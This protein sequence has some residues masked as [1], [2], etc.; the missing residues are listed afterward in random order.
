MKPAAELRSPVTR[1]PEPVPDAELSSPVTRLPEMKP[2]AEMR[3]PVTML[4]SPCRCR[5]V[6]AVYAVTRDE[7]LRTVLSPVTRFPEPVP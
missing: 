1:L 7:A 4:P 6:V 3:S 5:V 2:A